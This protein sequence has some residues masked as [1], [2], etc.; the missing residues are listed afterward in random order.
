MFLKTIFQST[1]IQYLLIRVVIF[2][3]VVP[4]I[5]FWVLCATV[6]Y[7]YNSIYKTRGIKDYLLELYKD[8]KIPSV[9]GVAGILINIVAWNYLIELIK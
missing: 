3:V 4:A 6:S 2:C 1:K 7:F 9:I 5:L 8:D